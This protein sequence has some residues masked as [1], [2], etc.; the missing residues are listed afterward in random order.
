VITG[1]GVVSPVGSWPGPFF[2]ALC[3]GAS[4]VRAIDD[5][6]GADPSVFT[7][8]IAARAA[9]RAGGAVLSR[10]DLAALAGIEARDAATLDRTTLLALA[11]GR[12]AA[13][14]AGLGRAD[15]D[16]AAV[17]IGSGMGCMETTD[18]AMRAFHAEGPRAVKTHT[19]PRGMANAPAAA[20]S[21]R[22]GAHGAHMGV[23]AACASG[24]LS[25]GGAARRV[26]SGE[27]P[28]AL[29]G[30]AEACILPSVIAAWQALRVLS[31][32]NE[33]PAGACRPFDKDRDGL[34]LGEGAAVLV[35]EE[36]DRAIARGA[37]IHAE[38]LGV[39]ASSDA[40]HLTAPSADGEAAAIEKALRD[41]GLTAA[42]VDH[43]SAHGTA[44]ALNDR[45]EAEALARAL[46]DRAGRVPVTALKSMLGHGIGAGG[47]LET[48]ALALT[49]ASGVV[50]PTLNL[51]ALDP[52]CPLDVVAG[53]A[54]RATL[55][56][57]LKT[58]FAFGGANAALLLGRA[59]R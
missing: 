10:A 11:A 29:A 38:V 48:A 59:D 49:L 41:A 57:G 13:Q 55:G 43:V 50:P 4:G 5:L 22:L 47:A 19:I 6:L 8:R 16:D 27:V 58:S 33:D 1:I 37:R 17:V 44:T 32:R 35:L 30:G 23:A 45:V 25:I 26:R 46:G 14:E 28:V 21:M 31:R 2:E 42:D 9:A 40:A 53:A 34:V 7:S 20:L 54:R 15:L 12:A 24:T 56:T 36:R 39:G 3:A 51:A 18:E 52:A